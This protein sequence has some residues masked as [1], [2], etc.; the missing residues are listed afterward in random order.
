MCHKVAD[1]TLNLDLCVGVHNNEVGEKE[2]ETS[3]GQAE[4]PRRW[5][6]KALIFVTV[7]VAA[8]AT[9]ALLIVREPPLYPFLARA[10]MVHHEEWIE[11]AS[12]GP[13][14]LKVGGAYQISGDL[15]TVGNLVRED[16]NDP[17]WRETKKPDS[18]SFS[19]PNTTVTL[20]DRPK[21]GAVRIIIQSYRQPTYLDRM[22]LWYR[23]TFVSSK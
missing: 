9:F 13:G 1:H 4:I 8:I 11:F 3:L 16:L 5:P 23:K 17:S 22:R 18:I 12:T 19:Q 7:I 21:D 15:A 14:R 20:L 6:R 2:D 10:K